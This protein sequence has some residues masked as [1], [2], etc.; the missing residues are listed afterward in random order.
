[1]PVNVSLA[2]PNKRSVM[3]ATSEGTTAKDVVLLALENSGKHPDTL[4]L[5][6]LCCAGLIMH[7]VRSGGRGRRQGHHQRGASH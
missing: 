1:M 3:V 4:G 2:T 7:Q 6:A 5:Y